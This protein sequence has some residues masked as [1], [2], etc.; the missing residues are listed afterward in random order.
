MGPPVT[1]ARKKK[2]RA[3][4]EPSIGPICIKCPEARFIDTTREICYKTGGLY[5]RRLKVIVGKYEPCRL[6]E[7]RGGGKEK[8]A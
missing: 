6:P 3:S 7:G 2:N 8:G 1:K 5:C 4:A